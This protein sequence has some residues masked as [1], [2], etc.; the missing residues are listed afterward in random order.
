MHFAKISL[1]YEIKKAGPKN[2]LQ[3]HTNV[4]KLPSLISRAAVL[5]ISFVVKLFKDTLKKVLFLS[6][7]FIGYVHVK[8]K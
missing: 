3:N 7:R 5:I 4:Q 2:R 1:N 8:C 6:K